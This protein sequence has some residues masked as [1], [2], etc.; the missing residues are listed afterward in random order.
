MTRP[1]RPMFS[2]T[3]DPSLL[4]SEP[5]RVALGEDLGVR[6][7]W[8]LV[9]AELAG[10]SPWAEVARHSV[11][12]GDF[13]TA[14]RL[15][16]FLS[17]AERTDVGASLMGAWKLLF[18]NF[19]K[20]IGRI[21]RE[22]DAWE[23]SGFGASGAREWLELAREEAR[24][25]PV[26]DGPALLAALAGFD[27]MVLT[28]VQDALAAADDELR[29]LHE[30][31]KRRLQETRSAART[32]K[33]ELDDRI[34]EL[35]EVLG[36]REQELL[37]RASPEVLAAWRRHDV[38]SLGTLRSAIEHLAAGDPDE[39]VALI[40]A[41]ET[42]AAAAPPPPKP[43]SVP[44]PAPLVAALPPPTAAP[45][46]LSS[47]AEARLSRYKS[48]PA[49]D[50]EANV[51]IAKAIDSWVASEL[52]ELME[53]AG[54][55]VARR[56][57]G[58]ESVRPAVLLADAKQ[59][60]LDGDAPQGQALFAEA[61]TAALAGGRMHDAE[62]FR[63]AAAWGLLV[64]LVLPH[65]PAD[66]RS[67]ALDPVNLSMLFYRRIGELPLRLLDDLNLIGALGALLAALDAVPAE[68]VY[69]EYL[70]PYLKDR[71]VALSEL[72]VGIFSA[73]QS[74]PFAALCVLAMLLRD[75]DAQAA[76][77]V[78]AVS[79]EIG[80]L[81][82]LRVEERWWEAIERVRRKIAG[83]S[84]QDLLRRLEETFALLQQ[85]QRGK[86]AKGPQ[87]GARLLTPEPQSRDDNAY[88]VVEVFNQSLVQPL[89]YLRVDAAVVDAGERIEHR[90]HS[91]GALAVLAPE[92]RAEMLVRLPRQATWPDNARLRVRFSTAMLHG[93]QTYVE[94]THESFALRPCPSS[95]EPT[96]KPDNPYAVGGA[97][98]DPSGI[99]GRKDEIEKIVRSLVGEKRDNVVVV[100]GERRMGKTTVLNAV[101][102]DP[103]V[104]D[105]YGARVVRVDVQD[106]P[107]GERAADFFVHRLIDPIVR[108]LTSVGVRV[109]I[110]RED[111]FAKSPYEAFKQFMVDLDGGLG[112]Q[113][114]LIVI[115]ELEKLLTVVDRQK[116]ASPQ[117]LGSEVMASMRAVMMQATRLSFILAG[118]TDV[119]RRHT[120]QH[121]NR[122]FRLGIEIEIKAISREAANELVEQPCRVMYEVLPAARDVIVGLTGRQPYLV[123]YVGHHLFEHM[124]RIGATV[125]TRREVEEVIRR[126]IIPSARAFEHFVEAVHDPIDSEI[127]RALAALQRTDE[128][129]PVAAVVRH[130]ARTRVAPSEDEVTTRLL[131]LRDRSPAVVDDMIRLTRRFR[132]T[133]GLYARRLRFLQRDPHGL[134]VRT[135]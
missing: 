118:V 116:D 107:I 87:L 64:T 89:R 35:I 11:G 32:L 29:K 80:V 119:L 48:A 92:E 93:A 76:A 39:L 2:D 71:P 37:T 20:E 86:G 96:H 105:R 83:L 30:E 72:A 42:T 108:R 28:A 17:D 66:E 36:P 8:P 97:V 23:Q 100:L 82:G 125:A 19:D 22:A 126:D 56:E 7:M 18:E 91:D 13:A 40:Q 21:A 65:L 61:L 131:A 132:L 51:A 123:Q 122:L 55:G 57:P 84:E 98:Q 99:V 4:S 60:L 16:N 103:K 95:A 134:L 129:V 115:D 46:K 73:P 114:V 62:R 43:G 15:I 112:K 58:W 121:A 90:A 52:A 94:A 67:A 10:R 135:I 106:V 3:L 33:S 104:K 47:F 77:R 50:F 14:A 117:S 70:R 127:V 102:Q 113:R 81:P 6:R 133:V 111:F 53:R 63:D 68:Y 25:L 1:L 75:V 34:E 12:T 41:A 110:V 79:Q 44:P 54:G 38:A 88:V 124:V 49:G 24:N 109:P 101:A 128:T 78:E 69:C 31:Q 26:L 5:L 9:L 27:R 120:T 85:K 130:L 45:K 74:S 59:L